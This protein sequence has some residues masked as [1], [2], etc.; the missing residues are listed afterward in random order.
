MMTEDDDR[1]QVQEWD[2]WK[3]RDLIYDG[4]KQMVGSFFDVGSLREVAVIYR[5]YEKKL[6]NLYD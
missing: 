3:R 5:T 4:R 1:G 2:I 6:S